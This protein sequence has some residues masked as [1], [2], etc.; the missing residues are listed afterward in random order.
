MSQVDELLK[1]LR[2]APQRGEAPEVAGPLAPAF[3]L[4][5]RVQR[6]TDGRVGKGGA[7]RPVDGDAAALARLVEATLRRGEEEAPAAWDGGDGMRA[8]H[9]A[10]SPGSTEPSEAEEYNGDASPRDILLARE[11]RLRRE[12]NL[13]ARILD[14]MEHGDA[15]SGLQRSA[16]LQEELRIRCPAGGTSGGRF[17]VRNDLGEPAR[18]LFRSHP[19][20]AVPGS[21]AERARLTVEPAALDLAP[22]DERLVRI[23]IDLLR[24]P[25]LATTAEFVVDA[26]AGGEV[27]HKLW[28]SLEV[29]PS[30][31]ET[32]ETE[33]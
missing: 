14:Q 15:V 3:D 1:R 27:L 22:G 28:V 29:A 32:A 16:P 19:L 6:L 25:R 13:T 20:Y 24:A 8:L 33:P 9:R 4:L 10:R 31:R 11:R 17:V 26:C 21:V 23:G 30:E 5:R 12:E 7:G 18:I 2:A